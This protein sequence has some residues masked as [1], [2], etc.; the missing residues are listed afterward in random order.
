MPEGV[1]SFLLLKV[2]DEGMTETVINPKFAIEGL[3]MFLNVCQLDS[4]IFF[5]LDIA[6]DKAF[7]LI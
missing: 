6:G 7:F 1:I 5:D 3:S 2:L 4:L